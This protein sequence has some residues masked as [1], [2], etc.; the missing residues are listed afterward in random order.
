MKAEEF[1]EVRLKLG[2]SELQ[3]A[4]KIGKSVKEVID[5]ENNNIPI[6]RKVALYLQYLRS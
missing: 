5:Y 4:R 3:M 2:F 1:R 6:D